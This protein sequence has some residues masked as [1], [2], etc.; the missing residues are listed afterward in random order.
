MVT[1]TSPTGF[2]TALVLAIVFVGS[3]AIAYPTLRPYPPATAWLLLVLATLP[4]AALGYVAGLWNPAAVR[5]AGLAA[6]VLLA[7]VVPW[8]MVRWVP[9]VTQPAEHPIPGAPAIVV[10]AAPDGNWDLYL[11]PDG[12]SSNRVVLTN[13][14]GDQER[15]PQLSPVGSR[16]VY[17]LLQSD[18]THDLYLMELDGT[19]PVSNDLLLAG[20]GD[21]TDTSWSPDGTRLLV[22]SGVEGEG[23]RI[24]LLELAT[25]SLQPIFDNASNPE[26]SPD[27]SRIVYV[28][29]R[30]EA[31]GNADIFVADAD[32]SEPQ[33]VVDTGYDDYFPSWSPEGSEIAFT[34]RVDG[35]DEDV[36]V[37]D[38]SGGHLRNLTTDSSDS[39][40]TYG[41]TPS[42]R[43]LFL[44]DRS[45]TGGTFL[46]FMDPDGSDVRLAQIL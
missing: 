27:G 44:S 28:S 21:L 33:A 34:S 45:G 31:P 32:G 40:E 16:L 43:I 26:W 36:F 2:R 20:P 23:S 22:R 7:A 42:G 9:G 35:G 10:S 37:V 8:A 13:T 4:I 39:E 5:P 1:R 41:W 17:G 19:R 3:A 12:D 11:L 38:V 25:G 18:G 30:R 6:L 46:Y 29:Y 15:F 24:Y 14:P